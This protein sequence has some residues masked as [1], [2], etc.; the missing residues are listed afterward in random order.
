MATS[1]LLG[2]CASAGGVV[3]R[4]EYLHIWGIGRTLCFNMQIL[5]F[6]YAANKLGGTCTEN[7]VIQRSQE[8]KQDAPHR[9]PHQDAPGSVRRLGVKGKPG[10]EPLVLSAWRN[11]G[12]RVGRCRN[13][14]GSGCGAV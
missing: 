10:Q 12:V 8:G 13:T 4:L 1:I 3:Q 9:G 11:K 2:F 6:R 5:S 7:V 14:A